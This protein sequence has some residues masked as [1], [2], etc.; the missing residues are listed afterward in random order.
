MTSGA[1]QR[2]IR[3]ARAVDEGVTIRQATIADIEVLL[4]HRVAMF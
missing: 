1:W 4:D 3:S 2:E